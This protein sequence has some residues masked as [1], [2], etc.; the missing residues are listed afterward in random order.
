MTYSNLIGL[1]ATLGTAQS[2]PTN[3]DF[4]KELCAHIMNHA[5]EVLDHEN[6][7]PKDRKPTI[8]ST[9][10]TLRL[11]VDADKRVELKYEDTSKS[12]AKEQS[13]PDEIMGLGDILSIRYLNT[14][15]KEIGPCYEDQNLDGFREPAI[16]QYASYD[17]LRNLLEKYSF[18]RQKDRIPLKNLDRKYMGEVRKYNKILRKRKR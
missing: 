17:C 9:S 18:G 7:T 13:R 3:Q 2:T 1:L 12:D 8:G 6:L 11:P 14:K 5:S 4:I 16:D 10:Y 15:G